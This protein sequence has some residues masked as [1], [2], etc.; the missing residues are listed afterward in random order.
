MMTDETWVVELQVEK[1]LSGTGVVLIWRRY[2][3]ASNIPNKP[4]NLPPNT[5]EECIAFLHT[6]FEHALD[7]PPSRNY[8]SARIR[9]LVTDECIPF[10]AL[11]I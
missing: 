8:E 5:L 10:E 1:W 9:N 2:I 4:I 6:R 7:K 11:G 3:T